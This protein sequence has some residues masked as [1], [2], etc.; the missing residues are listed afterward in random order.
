MLTIGFSAMVIYSTTP[1]C[2]QPVLDEQ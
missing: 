1:V 2:V